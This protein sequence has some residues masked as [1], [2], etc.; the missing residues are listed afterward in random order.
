MRSLIAWQTS[1]VDS[2][3]DNRTLLDR[4]ERALGKETFGIVYM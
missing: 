2:E 1:E 4:N 3:L